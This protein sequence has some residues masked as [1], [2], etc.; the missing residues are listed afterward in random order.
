MIF[1]HAHQAAGDPFGFHEFLLIA[2]AG[3]GAA[4]IFA[5]M[6][7]VKIFKRLRAAAVAAWLRIKG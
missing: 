7:I 1:F 6:Q 2:A 5:R 4:I 3:G